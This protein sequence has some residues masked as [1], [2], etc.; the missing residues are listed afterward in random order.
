[1]RIITGTHRGKKLV[2]A[3]ETITRPTA[4]RAKEMLFNMIDSR[5]RAAD[6]Q[7]GDICFADVFAGSGSMGLEAASRGAK[8]VWLFESHPVALKFLRQ[9]VAGFDVTVVPGDA[10]KPI[11]AHR[12]VDI[13][14]LDPPYGKGLWERALP[15]FDAAGWIDEHTVVIVEIDKTEKPV[16]PAG[17]C[18]TEQRAAGRN[19]FLW[20]VKTHDEKH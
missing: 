6:K 5:L 17:F 10:C 9:N 11:G 19:T 1:M 15:A 8:A 7:W 20:I 13:L 4:D 14:F 3:P 16:L 18:I 12:P 2:A